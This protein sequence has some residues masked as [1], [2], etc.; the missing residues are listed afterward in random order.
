MKDIVMKAKGQVL[1]YKDVHE[2]GVGCFSEAGKIALNIIKQQGLGGGEAVL[3]PVV[4]EVKGEEVCSNLIGLIRDWILRV[5]PVLML[6][7][8]FKLIYSLC[9]Q[10]P[11]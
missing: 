8:V 3:H 11:L 4:G 9:Q 10:S 1:L 5:F 6:V 2:S 7:F